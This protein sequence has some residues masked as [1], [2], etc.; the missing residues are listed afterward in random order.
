MKELVVNWHI[1]EKCNYKCK[2][3]FAHWE[4]RACRDLVNSAEDS[5]KLLDQ[6]AKLPSMLNFESLR[7][8]LVGGET[9]LYPEQII[10]LVEQAKQR[11]MRLSAITNGSL[12]DDELNQIIGNNFDIIGFSVDSI[13]PLT[14]EKIGRT[15]KKDRNNIESI[16]N[17]I[18]AIKRINPTITLKINT[19]VNKLN[20]FEN[21]GE[22]IHLANPDK[23]KIFQMLPLLDK[24]DPLIITE[25]QFQ[26]FL[27]NHEKYQEIIST[28]KNDEMTQS[29]LMIDP[30]G[31]FFQND[32]N[33]KGY[34]YSD[35]ILQVGI[36]KAFSK[37]KFDIDKFHHRYK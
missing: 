35:E 1:T 8:N 21:M 27:K 11:K 26:L 34:I 36:Q 3:C 9:F 33:Q 17:H 18:K 29:Y 32:S 20:Y 24:A 25:E 5:I 30:Y 31:R 15:N 4:K 7:L 37:I 10:H 6:I 13:H 14:N 12:L 19:V 23:W 2:Y 16:I 28:E 22:F